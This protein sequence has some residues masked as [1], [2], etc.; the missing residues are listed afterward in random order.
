[1]YRIP[2]PDKFR[3]NIRTKL[4]EQMS[5]RNIVN[6]KI[7]R[8][9]ERAIFNYAIQEASRKKI[10]KKWEN[11]FFSQIYVDRLRSIYKN[12]TPDIQQALHYGQKIRSLF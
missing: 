11:P 8:N 4:Q 10:I 6:D 2:Q 7:A 12:L 1:M 9:L 3:E 5:Q